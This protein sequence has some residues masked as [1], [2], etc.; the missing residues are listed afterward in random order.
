MH[1]HLHWLN[2]TGDEFF[3]LSLVDLPKS[4]EAL[5]AHDFFF[6]SFEKVGSFFGSNQHIN[7]IDRTERVEKL[8]E[9]Y[10]SE[11]AG[12]SGDQN[13]FSMVALGDRHFNT[14]LN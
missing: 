3:E 12:G 5:T 9:E 2:F 6:E 8:F 11:E 4:V 13:S 7:F 1:Q 14:L 10:F